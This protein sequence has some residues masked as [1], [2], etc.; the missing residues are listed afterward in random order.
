MSSSRR[1]VRSLSTC[2][3]VLALAHAAMAQDRYRPESEHDPKV[4][5]VDSVLGH[6]VGSHPLLHHEVLR[7]CRALAEAS[8]SVELLEYGR[9]HEGRPLVILVIGRPDR[10]KSLDRIQ[11]GLAR[12]GDPRVTLSAEERNRLLSELP[13]VAYMGHSIHGDEFSGTEAGLRLAYELVASRD[14][15]I[16]EMRRELLVLMDPVLNP[17]GR[18]RA[19]SIL[20]SFSGR[21][22][23][24]DP[25]SLGHVGTWPGGRTNH[26]F[27]DLNRDG[28]HLVHPE[29]RAR[30]EMLHRFR[31]QLIVDAHEMGSGSSFLFSPPR[32]PFNPHLPA[33]LRTWWDRFAATEAAAFDREGWT[34]YDGEWFEEFFPGRGRA[35]WPYLGVID[36]LHEQASTDGQ[37]ITRAGGQVR[38]YADAVHRQF[39]SELADLS[40][41]ARYRRELLLNYRNVREEAME[42]GRSG[43]V[44]AYYLSPRLH[45]DRFRELVEQLL[46]LGVELELTHEGGKLR[47]VVDV[48]SGKSG[49]AQV[50]AGSVRIRLDQPAGLLVR[51]L[52]DP[53][54]DSSA[55]FQA[56]ERLHRER[57]EGSRIYDVT[58]WSLLLASGLESFWS[59]TL[60]RLDW[61]PLSSV[62]GLGPREGGLVDG[63]AAQGWIFSGDEDGALGLASDLL[64]EG[65]PL[66]VVDSGGSLRGREFGRGSFAVFVEDEPKDPVP[67]LKRLALRRA[68]TVRPLETGL[69]EEGPD[70]GGAHWKRLAAPRVAILAG[71]PTDAYSVGAAWHLLDVKFGLRTSL[72]ETTRVRRTDL[73]RYSVIVVPNSWGGAAFYRRVLGEAGLDALKTWVENGGTLVAL[74]AGVDL[75]CDPAWKMSRVRLRRSVLDE[76]PPARFGLDDAA[77]GA[78]APLAGTGLD[79]RGQAGPSPS[80]LGPSGWLEALGIPGDGEPVLGRGA[81]R[82]L[83]ISDELD[84]VALPPTP[85]KQRRAVDSR[86]RRFGPS[87]AFLS[88]DMDEGHFLSHGTGPSLAVLARG[89]RSLIAAGGV[90]TAGRFAAPEDLHLGGLL[91]PEAAGR[92]SRTA[93]VTRE[94]KGSGQVILFAFDPNFRGACPATQRVFLNAVVLGP[95]LGT[96]SKIGW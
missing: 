54:V 90:T 93:W 24:P 27:F 79:V 71:S 80:K 34:Y 47:R 64:A 72:L 15:E 52:L 21:Y 77:I 37:S 63:S 62:A 19:I 32:H 16:V 9:S 20:R 46:A 23:N 18:E 65:M 68:V 30:L 91:W 78:V 85:S 92:L 70:L 11:A 73:S 61:R 60:D 41:A 88:V 86:L 8:A 22:E 87:G 49:D 53:H 83:G 5:T 35:I 26:Y 13:A 44:R 39:V 25:E 36:I 95:G 1:L 48:A 28:F 69:A 74:A 42:R 81:R 12:L 29:S 56:E 57:A 45:G 33:G 51:S 4:P 75:A 94:G 58:A 89:Q 10:L 6:D 43:R 14:A 50:P 96:R 66:R 2:L 38:T 84:L 76:H 31:P 67:T 59:A 40:A 55:A 7:Y 82:L 17:D 3:F